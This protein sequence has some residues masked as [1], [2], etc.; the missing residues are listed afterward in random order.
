MLASVMNPKWS[1]RFLDLAD[2]LPS[3]ELVV[4]SYEVK[5]CSLMPMDAH[6]AIQFDLRMSDVDLL[7]NYGI[8]CRDIFEFITHGRA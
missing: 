3:P 2:K 8:I 4:Q 7:E 5:K 1:G 6:H